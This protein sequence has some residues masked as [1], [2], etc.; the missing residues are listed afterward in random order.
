METRETFIIT[1]LHDP[2][3]SPEPRGRVRHVASGREATFKALPDLLPLL[4]ALVEDE[5]YAACEG[6]PGEAREAV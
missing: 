2:Q 5:Q 1:L 6:A 3:R 4:S